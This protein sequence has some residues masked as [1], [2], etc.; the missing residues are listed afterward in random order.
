MI[1]KLKIRFILLSMSSLLVLLSVI[2]VGMNVIN[3][4]S[5]VSETDE[6]LTLLSQNKG[7]FPDNQPEHNGGNDIPAPELPGMGQGNRLPQ[8]MSP[9]LPYESRYFSVL[10]DP[11]DTVIY[12]DISRITAV[13]EAAAIDYADKAMDSGKDRG[14][15]GDFRFVRYS[16]GDLTR[17][18][19][20]DCGRRLDSFYTFL[21]T[22]IFIA[23]AGLITVFFVI[24]F[25]AGR[26]IR[27]IAES[28]EKQKRFITD[29]GHE[30]KTP[31]TIINANVDILEMEIGPNESLTDITQQT[32]RL[33]S[34]TN[35]LVYLARMEEAENTL[36]MIELPVSEIVQETA[37]SFNAL[38]QA[39]G[40]TLICNIQP[41]LSL[42]GNLK[43]IEQLVS[44]LMDN[45][46]KYSPEGGI[47]E[48]ELSK[49]NRSVVLTV[50]N[51]TNTP[52][53]TAALDSVFDRF[54]RAD[55]SRNSETG[56]HG[57]GLSVAKA[58]VTAHGGRITASSKDN[59][60]F[61][62]T[63]VFPT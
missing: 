17:I 60:S 55:P 59:R 33:T 31:L 11:G 8:H 32:K 48:L 63:A 61:K 38:A 30:I 2:V 20:L 16:E 42:N 29:A 54:Y 3:Y 22:S 39:D 34:L 58:I 18:T 13:D 44:V 23:F 19:F 21:Y 62:I 40:K 37:T 43:A 7:R 1:R 51:T 5:V 10:L 35:D 24:C 57:I 9:E 25:F 50:F 53:D 6:I 49:Q 52:I 36:Q 14:F 47:I 12:T 41:L 28:Y 15:V 26:I 46:L 4:T 27:P 56:G 45:A